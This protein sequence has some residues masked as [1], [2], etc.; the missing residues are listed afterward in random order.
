MSAGAIGGVSSGSPTGVNRF[1]DMTS[2]EFVK[3]L[4]SELSNQDPLEPSDSTAIL[5][6]LSSLRNIESQLN[7]QQRLE[8][9]VTQNEL[10]AASGLIGKTVEGLDNENNN[11]SGRVTAV[12]IV[13]QRAFLELENGKTLRVDRVTEITES[14]QL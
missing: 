14:P 8:S 3:V 6:Q 12:R 1:T 9:L 4:L 7:L 13:N 5:E 10:S 2:D 11:T